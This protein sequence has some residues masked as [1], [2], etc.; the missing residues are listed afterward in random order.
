MNFDTKYLIRWGIPG[1]V[2]LFWITLSWFLMH[3]DLF[4]KLLVNDKNLQSIILLLASVGIGV[5]IGYLCHQTVFAYKWTLNVKNMDFSKIK[6][7]VENVQWPSQ[8]RDMYFH[9]E[10]IWQNA[11]K[12]IKDDDQRNYITG[13]YRHYLSTIHGLGA[14]FLSQLLST[15][16][17]VLIIGW[18]WYFNE[19]SWLN[20]IPLI[21]VAIQG[22]LSWLFWENYKYFSDLL[23]DYQ[24]KMLAELLKKNT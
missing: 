4:D 7:Q 9:L 11:I 10:F 15:I 23:M 13:R 24:G 8:N 16:V 12:N 6:N 5:T 2:F 19:F 17:S 1:W 18:N 14:L 22:F 20:L 21:F 3:P